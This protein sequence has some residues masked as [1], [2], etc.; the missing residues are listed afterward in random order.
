MVHDPQKPLVFPPRK[1][2]ALVVSRYHGDITSA[3]QSSCLNILGAAGAKAD[4]LRVVSVPGAWEIPLAIQRV[5]ASWQPDVVV[6]F[7]AVIRGET[8]HYAA[9]IENVARACMDIQLT[10]DTPV[11]FEVLGGTR[12]QLVARTIGD[13]DKGKEAATATLH[14]LHD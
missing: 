4:D 3:L 10:G 6:V 11:V 14:L 8:D 1:K 12:E 9:I 7:G 5:I 2:V 13:L